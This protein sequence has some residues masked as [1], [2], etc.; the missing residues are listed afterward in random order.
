MSLPRLRDAMP[1]RRLAAKEEIAVKHKRP[2]RSNTPRCLSALLTLSLLAATGV[3]TQAATIPVDGVCTLVDAIHAANTDLPTG[4]CPGGSGSDLILLEVDVELVAPDHLDIGLPDITSEIW[5]DGNY[6]SIFRD[7]GAEKFRIFFVD[8][9]GDLG[10]EN[11]SVGHGALSSGSGAGVLVADGGSLTLLRA[12]FHDHGTEGGASAILGDPNS[13]VVIV[14]S[15]IREN[16]G[17]AALLW[18]G[19]TIS[20]TTFSDNTKGTPLALVDDSLLTNSTFSDNQGEV[21]FGHVG[22]VEFAQGSSVALNNTFSGNT[23]HPGGVLVSGGDAVLRNSTFVK[24]GGS[25]ASV[26]VYGYEQLEMG[27]NVFL[28]DDPSDHCWREGGGLI[29]D[30]GGNFFDADSG[31]CLGGD[32]IVGGTDIDLTLAF[33]EG[34]TKTHALTEDS[35]AVEAGVGCDLGL[36]QQG[37]PRKDPCD[38]GS[39]EFDSD[40]TPLFATVSVAGTCP[41]PM[42][43]ELSGLTPNASV[44][45][46][47]SRDRGV[48]VIENGPCIGR[49][50]ERPSS[51][52]IVPLSTNGAGDATLSPTL[53]AGACDFS[54]QVYDPTSCAITK[55]TPIP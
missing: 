11:V 14:K 2:A 23:G 24:N 51:S 35:V 40:L 46:A 9:T 42:S 43:I 18:E 8:S 12:D 30:T 26:M 53:S 55:L 21:Y 49:V 47:A 4:F 17:N 27:N 15:T 6:H 45:L 52:L 3:A 41:G 31:D 28:K 34:S 16:N 5:I 38:S 22:A 48:T 33:N 1:N 39:Y 20:E 7:S 44:L 37:L 25:F 10:L 36:D 50:L 19:G 29:I 54:F 32:T 13:N